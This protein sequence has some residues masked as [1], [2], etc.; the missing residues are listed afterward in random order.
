MLH[1][2]AISWKGRGL[3]KGPQG[4]GADSWEVD[5]FVLATLILKCEFRICGGKGIAYNHLV[6]HSYELTLTRGRR[7][8]AV[9]NESN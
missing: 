1:A 6:G 7:K 4:R 2:T 3:L 8:Q 5:L 9:G